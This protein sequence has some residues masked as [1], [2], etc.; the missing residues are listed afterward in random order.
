[1]LS[2]K[3]NPIISCVEDPDLDGM[4][5]KLSNDRPDSGTLREGIVKDSQIELRGKSVVGI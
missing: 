1:M 4:P 2:V 3:V 5:E